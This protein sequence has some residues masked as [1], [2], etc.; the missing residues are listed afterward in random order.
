MKNAFIGDDGKRCC[1]GGQ[2]G[3]N[4]LEIARQDFPDI[5]A[6]PDSRQN[7]NATD[8]RGANGFGPP[9]AVGMVGIRWKLTDFMGGENNGVGQ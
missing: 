3:G 8:D 5:V 4:G 6:H 9:V 7:D 2:P 1:T